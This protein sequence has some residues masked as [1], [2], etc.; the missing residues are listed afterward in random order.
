MYEKQTKQQSG[1][2]INNNNFTQ[3]AY[4]PI[5]LLISPFSAHSPAFPRICMSERI[6][7][8]FVFVICDVMMTMMISFR[9]RTVVDHK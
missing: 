7:S 4:I 5:S 2:D 6:V 9:R 8:V 3:R 1:N